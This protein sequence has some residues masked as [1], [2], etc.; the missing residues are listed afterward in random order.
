M[1][2]AEQQGG[3]R[4]LRLAMEARAAPAAAHLLPRVGQEALVVV[5][6]LGPDDVSGRGQQLQLRGGRRRRRRGGWRCR[7]RR[8]RLVGMRELG[9]DGALLAPGL[10]EVAGGWQAGRRGGGEAGRRR[11]GEAGRLGGGKARRGN[12]QCNTSGGRVDGDPAFG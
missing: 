8:L 11:C 9:C 12:E 4:W 6:E 10:L 7:Q 5:L 3:R 2:G 1:G